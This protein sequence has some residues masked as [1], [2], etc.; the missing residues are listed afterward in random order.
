MPKAVLKAASYI[1][2]HAPDMVV[3]NGTTQTI[4]RIVNPDSEYL[5]QLPSHL[6][7]YDEVLAYAPNQIF[8]GNYSPEYLKT[9]PSPWYSFQTEKRGRSGAFGEIIPEDE[10]IGLMK[11]VDA[12]K[13]VKLTEDFT[14]QVKNKF[15]EHPLLISKVDLIGDGVSIDEID[16]FIV[17]SH[18]EPLV[19]E[20]KTVGC[21]KRAHD[22][23]I[24][25]SAHTMFENLASKASATLAML[26]LAAKNEFDLLEADYVIEC[27]EEACG[28]MNQRGGGN[29]AKA[30][31]EAAGAVNATGS[32]TR[33]FCAAPAH[34][35]IEAASLVAA[36]TFKNVVI[37]AGGATA[38]LGMNGKDH[39]KKGLPILED[40]LGGFAALVS[41][42]D[43]LNPIINLDCVGRHTVGTG[44]AP[45]AVITSLSSEPLNRA[46]L[47][48]TDV[49][50]Y[51]V[52]LQNPD[53]TKPAGAGDVP[54]A[55]YK[56]LAALSVMKKEIERADIPAFIEKHGMPGFAPT[57]GHIPSG[58]PYLGFARER[59]TFGDLNR[60]MIIGKGSLFLGRMTNL[61]DG[62][63][64][65]LERN[66]PQ[67]EPQTSF[68]NN[69]AKR[70]FKIGI[71]TEGCEHGPGEWA[72]GARLT[73]AMR[74]DIEAV[75][76]ENHAEMER[77]LDSGEL[78]TCVTAH[79][80]FP[81]GV[82]TI[83]KISTPGRGREMYVAST[84]GA[85]ASDRVEAMVRNAICGV[86]AAKA[87]GVEKPTVGIL[88][89]DGAVRTE[90]ALKKLQQNGFEIHFAGSARQ[91]GGALMRGNDAL[92]GA[93]DVLVTDTLTGNIMMKML[94]SFTTGGVYES[95]G[96][97]YGP[98]LGE[99]Y[100]R[101]VL[102]LSRASGAPVAANA[103]TYAAQLVKGDV[104]KKVSDEFAAA[105]KAGLDE[106]VAGL[107]RQSA[108]VSNGTFTMP[109]KEPVS[110]EITGIDIL[111]LENAVRLLHS[112]GIY[113]ESGMG[114]TGPV[115][116]VS[117]E[118]LERAREII[119]SF[120]C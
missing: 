95:V 38:K 45:Q 54:E 78:D 98:G 60:I 24:N 33:G 69:Q 113:A 16:K 20:N 87:S 11:T 62:V 89:I 103:I 112:N 26:N 86:A 61:F 115:A 118:N 7:S 50:K 53:I 5:R 71:T 116:M 19:F 109:K 80:N 67:V 31:A 82:T 17:E 32:D 59:L 1:L 10:F 104:F 18:A 108:Q 22:I 49:D 44:S 77:L 99:N 111:E 93:A 6:R 70:I 4:E 107:A 39:V 21:V 63:S 34:A 25:L 9:I 68:V 83:G 106:I 91:D 119:S 37:V 46:G 41:E 76:V 94:S 97:G 55:N 110:G 73:K 58:V 23:D 120:L 81:I 12:F 85:S 79:Y 28:D 75:A 101:L 35:L 72:E 15:R 74:E 102:I 2:V 66:N 3:L 47:R 105:R 90:N 57:Q 114:C 92:C 29:F 64:V 13:L 100:K 8:I 96:S 30:I 42:D 88:N 27:S 14:V 117:Q 48:L 40:M 52:E 56:M 84:T 65:L 36:G 51:A 43:G